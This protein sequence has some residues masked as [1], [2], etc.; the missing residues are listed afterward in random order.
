MDSLSGKPVEYATIAVY[1]MEGNKIL[2]GTTSLGNGTFSVDKIP[3]GTYKIVIDFIG[4]HRKTISPVKVDGTS[5]I[6]IGIIRISPSVTTLSDVSITAQRNIIENKI[7]KLIYNA[8]NDITSQSGVATDVLKKVPQVTVDINGNV[9]LQ[10]NSNIRFLIDGKPSTVFGN[11]IADVLQTIPASRIQSIEVVTSPGAKYDAEGTGGIINILLKKTTIKGIS[12][13]ASLSGGTRLENGSF[14]M[15]ARTGNIGINAYLSG[16][17][18]LPSTTLNSMD[19]WSNDSSSQTNM[20]QSGRSDFTRYGFQ[21][22]IGFDWNITPKDNITASFNYNYNGTNSTN[23]TNQQIIVYDT[24]RKELSNQVNLLKSNNDNHSQTYDWSVNYKHNFHHKG[25]DLNLLYTSSYSKNYSSYQQTQGLVIPDS[26]LTGSKGTNPGNNREIDLS[27]DYSLPLS[28]SANFETGAK[29]VFYELNSITDAYTF[30][31][32]A[33]DY[34]PDMS[35]SYSLKYG[36]NIYAAYLSGSFSLFHWLDVKL[37]LRYEFTQTKI[38][39]A[40]NP[41]V[42]IPDYNTIAPSLI[43]SHSFKNNHVLKFSYSYRIQRPDYRELNPFI[44]L[45]D[46]HN[47]TTGNPELTPELVNAFELSYN[48]SFSKG[49]NINV[50]A[51]YRRN[52][53]DIQSYVN[54][55]PAYKIGDSI[56]TDVTLTSRQ[57]ISLEQRGGLNL[58]GSFTLVT[59]LNLRSNISLYDRYIVNTNGGSGSINS[60]EYRINLNLTYQLPWDLAFEFFGNFNSTRTN[61][62]G[63][64]PSFTSYSLAIRKQLFKKK[65]SIAIISTNPF[66]TYVNQKTDLTGDNFTLTTL[67]QVPYRSFGINFTFKFGNLKFKPQKNEEHNEIMNPPEF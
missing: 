53:D 57:N 21:S 59:G 33:N 52:T 67:R 47:I 3:K 43:L 42:E 64:V 46:P 31:P 48:K 62:Q 27:I 14:N 1:Q 18:Q 22:G 55:Y 4:F 2:T 49:G 34:F 54:Y 6:S 5:T 19:R 8:E 51:F 16:N 36:R 9:E 56:Y 29:A 28:E 32:V 41:N 13:N 12:G 65:A 26:I 38:V 30:T 10:G 24:A 15:N 40:N 11:N 45:S 60:Y 7:D 23:T 20:T 63:K 39:Y 61:I 35:Q 25:H 17:T 37:G 50:V 58:Y 66:N 44:N